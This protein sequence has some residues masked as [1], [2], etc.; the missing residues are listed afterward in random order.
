MTKKIGGRSISEGNIEALSIAIDLQDYSVKNI[1]S[2]VPSEK[3]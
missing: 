3:M 1:F 2:V